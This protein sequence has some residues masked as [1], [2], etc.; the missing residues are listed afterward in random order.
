MQLKGVIAASYLELG[1]HTVM[2]WPLVSVSVLYSYC[3]FHYY[4]Q[5]FRTCSS[6]P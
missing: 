5:G 4:Y 1:L 2:V 3:V 6:E